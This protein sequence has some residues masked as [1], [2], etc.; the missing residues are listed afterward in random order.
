VLAC[1]VMQ[2]HIL[3]LV[4]LRA[5]AVGVGCLLGM[6]MSGCATIEQIHGDGT[7][8]RSFAFAA[9][10]FVPA[11]PDGQA[12]IVKVTGLGLVTSNGAMTLG[13][14]HETKIALNRDCRVVLV[15]NTDEQLRR[16]FTLMQG[17]QSMCSDS[18]A[19]GG[20]ND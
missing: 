3:Y 10:I 17:T 13:W 15:G 18:S 2:N 5:F 20:V 16:F 19:I 7:I 1:G 8:T 9:P 6:A 4:D 12:H 11:D 14:F